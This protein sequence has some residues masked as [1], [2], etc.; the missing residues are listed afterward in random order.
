MFLRQCPEMEIQQVVGELVTS[1][2][3]PGLKQMSLRVLSDLSG[4]LSVACDPVG[5]PV[6]KWVFTAGGSAARYGTG[7]FEIYTDLTI[8]GIIDHWDQD[9]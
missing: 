8:L 9:S 6:G 1:R 4:K 7:D 2:R 3:V 5:A